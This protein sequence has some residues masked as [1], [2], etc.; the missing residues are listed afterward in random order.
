[1][2]GSGGLDIGLS[3]T[4]AIEIVGCVEWDS[5]ACETL[6]RS[7]DKGITTVI[8]ADIKE[9]DV[10]DVLESIGRSSEEID[11]IVGGPPC[12]A[13]SVFGKRRGLDDPRGNV[14]LDFVRFVEEIHPKAFV[15]ENVRGLLSMKH[16]G[17]K[18]GIYHLLIDAFNR[19][20]YRVDVFVVNS[21][22]Y[23][24]PQIRERVI[25]IGNRLQLVADFPEPTHSDKPMGDQQRFATLGDA[26]KGKK[27][28]DQGI[29]DFSPR[30]KGYLEMIPEG[31]NW[32]S[33]PEEIQK[34]S[35]G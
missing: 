21:V 13:F 20:G 26:I 15:M 18:G 10:P 17:E 30:K 14:I 5:D 31:G 3:N 4:G 9:L 24:A 23:G 34:E 2:S 33:M 22:N 35:M 19:L 12:Q 8:E 32:R 29:M 16:E 25:F 27:F 7:V 6:R 11:L 28:R 1:Y